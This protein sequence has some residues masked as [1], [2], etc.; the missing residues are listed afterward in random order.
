[1]YNRIKMLILSFFDTADTL[2]SVTLFLQ[3]TIAT[4]C[5]S[6]CNG[7]GDGLLGDRAI[8]TKFNR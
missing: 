8:P 4:T 6:S 7:S 5:S 3:R 2:L 1:M